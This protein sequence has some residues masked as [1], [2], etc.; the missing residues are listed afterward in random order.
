[1]RC[2]ARPHH[3]TLFGCSSHDRE[4]EP[5]PARFP[6]LIRKL[7]SSTV[8]NESTSCSSCSLGSYKARSENGASSICTAFF[9]CG[10][11][12]QLSLRHALSSLA[13]RVR[14]T[15][16]MSS[17]NGAMNGTSAAAAPAEKDAAGATTPR[18]C[19][20]GCGKKAGTLECPKCK[21]YVLYPSCL[22][23]PEPV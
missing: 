20:N 23:S 19:A 10:A 9:A 22:G 14:G 13:R 18:M 16:T 21:E 12:R 11:A 7:A 4:V 6:I 1:M 8:P 17:S 15:G 2:R 3:R 5:N